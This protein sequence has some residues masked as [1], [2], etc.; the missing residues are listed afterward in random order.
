MKAGNDVWSTSKNNAQKI[1]RLAGNGKT[2]IGPEKH[3]NGKPGYYSHYHIYN[4]SGGHS[5]Y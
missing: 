5:F 4:R 3:G 2:P 1:A